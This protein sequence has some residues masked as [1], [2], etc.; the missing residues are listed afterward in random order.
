MQPADK[1]KD[2]PTD[3]GVY[4]FR[5]AS[6]RVIYV[7]KAKNLKNRLS[8]Y[9]GR[10]LH[11][12]TYKMVTTA[13][14][15]DWVVV[16]SETEAL[17]LEYSWIKE[18]DP[19]F[20]VRFR[21]DKTYPYL[22]VTTKEEFPRAFVYRGDR[23]KGITYV[24]PFVH[25]WALRDTLDH[26]LR[27][28]PMRSCSNG[29]FRNAKAAKRPCLLADIDR[30]TAPCV[31]RIDAGDHRKIVNDFLTFISGDSQ[32]TI[33][34]LE[35]R[36]QEASEAQDY[37]RASVLRDDLR[38]LDRVRERGT[39]NLPMD[40]QADFLAIDHDDLQSAVQ[41][42]SVRHGRIIGQRGF[43]MENAVDF[44]PETLMTDAMMHAY[45]YATDQDIPVEI[46]VSVLPESS[47]NIES[48]LSEMRQ[49]KVSL[50]VPARGDKRA[51]M[52]TVMMNATQAL[53]AH[54]AKRSTDLVSRS[55]AL[56]E[57]Q[58]ALA[59]EDAPLRIECV[60]VSHIQGTNVVASLVVFE[61]GL[62]NKKDYRSFVIENPR[63]DTASIHEVVG[64]R[65]ATAEASTGPYRPNLL[66]IDG[67]LPQVNAAQRAL[68]EVGASDIH[69]VGLAKRMEEIWLPHAQYP[70]ILPRGSEALFLL[71][72][73]RDEAHRFAISHHRS[74]RSKSMTDSELDSV[75]GLGPAKKK[76][77]LAA[78]GSL[79]NVRGASLQELTT[80]AGIG[81]AL[82]EHI[83][84]TLH[85]SNEQGVAVNVTTGEII[86]L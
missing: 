7:G 9:F 4:R 27:V 25:T 30:C 75:P 76:A 18:Y 5:D 85:A 61:D 62:A 45:E 23:K 11:P 83:Y 1:P 3:A 65:F 42:F 73:V 69:V 34:D 43:V 49:A 16:R 21:D 56:S 63:D 14:S 22:A 13:T 47:H 59:L 20:N 81:P 64:R 28:F 58:Q 26:M 54:K 78:F 46:L 6:K 8:S 55:K 67:G 24:G 29:V 74:R 79:K 32:A 52:E 82:A 72:R 41:I 40:T 35:R 17:Q 68:I 48:L 57:I 77:L 53:A 15:V 31:D 10:D 80:A 2:I 86:D 37:E 12:R 66:V 51:L 19:T 33:K 44:T 36:M 70:V 84:Q 60:D 50:R 39:V 71:Q 38:A